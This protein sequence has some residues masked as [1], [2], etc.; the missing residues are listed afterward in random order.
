MHRVAGRTNHE[1]NNT[2]AAGLFYLLTFAASIPAWIMLAPVLN[3]PGY[4]TGAGQD[5][6]IAWACFLDF[7]NAL[8]GIGS[9][10]AVYPIVKRINN[11]MALGF[12]MSRMVEA[13]IIMIGVVALLAVVTLRQ[14]LAATA[15]DGSAVRITGQALVAGRDWTFLFGPGFMACF[16]AVLFGTLL[17]RSGLV[18][19]LIPAIGLIGAP[20][21]FTA[22]MLTLFG[23]NSPASSWNMLATLPIATWEVSVGFYMT[24]KGFRRTSVTEATA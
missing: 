11:S 20:L 19:R 16:N 12:V 10:V 1:R 14:E 8:A 24:V 3:D 23:H 9:A 21:L 17:Y 6:Q 4:I 2:R 5:T 22:N 13:A 18:P 7:V 15:A